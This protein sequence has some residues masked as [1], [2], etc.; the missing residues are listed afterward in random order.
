M[1][2]NKSRAGVRGCARVRGLGVGGSLKTN[3]P[4]GSREAKKGPQEAPKNA[5][6]TP[7]GLHLGPSGAQIGVLLVKIGANGYQNREILKNENH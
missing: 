5:P 2:S 3:Y 1:E 7:T 6:W 4:E